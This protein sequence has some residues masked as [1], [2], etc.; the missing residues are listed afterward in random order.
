MAVGYSDHVVASLSVV[1]SFCTRHLS[2][3]GRRLVRDRRCYGGGGA[4]RRRRPAAAPPVVPPAAGAF[5]D[6]GEALW[7]RTILM[8]ERCQPLDFAG[9]IHYDSFGRRLARPPN[10]RSASSLSSCCSSDI[11]GASESEA[12]YYIQNLR[13]DHVDL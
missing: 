10:P 7:R 12:S 1:V 11:L 3:A 6:K 4:D 8:G 5:G 9:A 13:S 2:R